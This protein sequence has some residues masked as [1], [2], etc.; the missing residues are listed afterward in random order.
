MKPR[1]N[2]SNN[3]PQIFMAAGI[4]G[5]VGAIVSAVIKADNVK[6][7]I[8]R[9]KEDV[10]AATIDDK[11]FGFKNKVDESLY[12]VKL[13]GK[14]AIDI[15]KEMAVPISLATFSTGCLLKSYK[16]MDNQRLI[17]TE[18]IDAVRMNSDIYKKA[19]IEEVGEETAK[20]ID[21]R[22]IIKEATEWDRKINAMPDNTWNDRNRHA[23]I[24]SFIRES[25]KV[26]P[27]LFVLIRC[28]TLLDSLKSLK[29]NL[30]GGYRVMATALWLLVFLAFIM[31]T[32]T[33]CLIVTT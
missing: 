2:I 5:F 12:K 14:A 1:M 13:V 16:I 32:M 17:L 20:K 18:T 26:G 21:D 6:P 3:S 8:N 4:I 19:T 9:T 7:I 27:V 31:L 15:S 23:L 24:N 25:V 10:K 22:V 33:A 28:V 30:Q 11:R 29:K